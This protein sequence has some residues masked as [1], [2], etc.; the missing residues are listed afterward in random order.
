[1]TDLGEKL[2]ESEL[3][4]ATPTARLMYTIQ[5]K[6]EQID[7]LQQKNIEKIEKRRVS[8]IHI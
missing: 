1:M 8:E 4:V 7:V 5:G 6:G 2:I 3:Q